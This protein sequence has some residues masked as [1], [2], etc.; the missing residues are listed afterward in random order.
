MKYKYSGKRP[1][2]ART[3]DCDLCLW[4]L[5]PTSVPGAGLVWAQKYTHPQ[6]Q[7][8]DENGARLSIQDSP[9]F[10]NPMTSSSLSPAKLGS[11]PG[12]C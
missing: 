10:F 4:V 9:E 5:E 3:G 6:L 12:F 11:L 7:K 8:P 2:A 1:R